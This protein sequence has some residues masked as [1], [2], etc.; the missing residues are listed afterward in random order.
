MAVAEKDEVV[1]CVA[2]VVATTDVAAVDVAVVAVVAVSVA[3]VV[4]AAFAMYFPRIW[5]SWLG[6]LA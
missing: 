6:C 1:F 5:L 2:S 3:V 4:A